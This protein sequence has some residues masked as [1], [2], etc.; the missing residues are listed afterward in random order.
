MK[1]ILIDAIS[2]AYDDEDVLH[3]FT[4]EI[5]AQEG[6]ILLAGRNGTG[7]STLLNLL[8]G[9]LLPY[10]GIVMREDMTIGYLPFDTPLFEHLSVLDNLRYYYR[11]FHGK[12]FVLEDEQVQKI[13]QALSID[14][15][16][17]RLDKCSSGQKQKAGIAM[18][19]MSGTDII[20]MDEPFVA[21]DSKSCSGLLRL[22]KEMK[23]TKTFLLTTHTIEQLEPIADRL[24][25]LKE[26]GI[27]LD[28]RN[29]DQIHE[30]FVED[31]QL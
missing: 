6:C 4:L 26:K 18:I 12:N 1:K 23:S 3:D 21:I 9:A 30:Y 7:K 29:H 17:Q 27:E 11:N 13:L 28:T 2:F 22:I 14:Y 31:H 10:E 16:E 8:A 15:L 20:V 19:L 25:L 24:I 5:H